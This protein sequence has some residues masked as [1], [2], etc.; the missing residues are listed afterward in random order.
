MRSNRCVSIKTGCFSVVLQMNEQLTQ[1]RIEAESFLLRKAK[2][3]DLIEEILA[4]Q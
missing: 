3:E 2:L 1:A 4:A